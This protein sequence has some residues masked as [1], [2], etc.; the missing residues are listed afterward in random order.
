MGLNHRSKH[1]CFYHKRND[2]HHI[3]G[4][5]TSGMLSYTTRKLVSVMLVS[6][7]WS[8]AAT[9]TATP[10]LT[11]EHSKT[12]AEQHSQYAKQ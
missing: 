9:Q 6:V 4:H 7:L 2:G 1:P 8:C 3:D 11:P 10:S 5:I 12:F